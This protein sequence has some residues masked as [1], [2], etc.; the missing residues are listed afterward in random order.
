MSFSCTSVRARRTYIL[1]LESS[2]KVIHCRTRRIP[3]PP[4]LLTTK[5]RRI[6]N[7]EIQTPP[8]LNYT[9]ACILLMLYLAFGTQ[10]MRSSQSPHS[11][12]LMLY[13][14]CGVH[15]V[16]SSQSP[17]STDCQ[18]LIDT[19]RSQYTYVL[20]YTVHF[21]VPTHKS[22]SFYYILLVIVLFCINIIILVTI[23]MNKLKI[24][25]Q[26][27]HEIVSAADVTTFEINSNV[28]NKLMLNDHA[29]L[30]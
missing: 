9:P 1:A 29:S 19:Y 28:S 6:T 12:L 10:C 18:I 2:T 24:I 3:W 5:L 13:R 20:L 27:G 21:M 23:M 26:F 11:I 25:V 22:A 7:Y 8:N 30:C 16:R 14:A 17:H 4:V 15:Y